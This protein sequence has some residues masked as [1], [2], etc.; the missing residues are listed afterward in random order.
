[1]CVLLFDGFVSAS[2]SLSPTTQPF[3]DDMELKESVKSET[4]T[5]EEYELKVSCT[6]SISVKLNTVPCIQHI[7]F[8]DIL[9]P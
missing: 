3:K 9:T 1:M 6:F 8:H 2:V 4:E 5:R 7:K